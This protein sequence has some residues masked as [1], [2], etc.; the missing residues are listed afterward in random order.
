MRTQNPA[1]VWEAATWNNVKQR[2]G[3]VFVCKWSNHL[4]DYLVSFLFVLEPEIFEK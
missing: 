2:E 1:A 4:K 3:G